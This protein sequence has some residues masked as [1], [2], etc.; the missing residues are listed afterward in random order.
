MIFNSR[1]SPW[2]FSVLSLFHSPFDIDYGQIFLCQ[3]YH[4]RHYSIPP[5]VWFNL[6]Y[7]KNSEPRSISILLKIDGSIFDEAASQLLD[8]VATIDNSN[9]IDETQALLASIQG[10][11]EIF[12]LPGVPVNVLSLE[13]LWLNFIFNKDV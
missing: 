1:L 5:R 9:L 13:F 11:Y 12:R 4:I 2:E 6:S 7:T 8:S 3:V 10:R